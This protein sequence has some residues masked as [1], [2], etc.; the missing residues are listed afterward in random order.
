MDFQQLLNNIVNWVATEGVKI[1]A[2]FVALYLGFKFINIVCRRIEKGFHKK[3]VDITIATAFVSTLRKVLKILAIICFIGFIGIETS[4]IA[5]AIASCGVAIGLALQGSLSN[6]AGGVVILF[7]RPYKIGDYVMIG[8]EE[9]TVEKIELFYTYLTTTDNKIIIIPNANASNETIINYSK[10]DSRRVDMVFQIAYENDFEKAKEIIESCAKSTGY[11]L[12]D[13]PLFVRVSAH[14]ASS[15]DIKAKMW[16]KSD[17]YWALYHDML[18][19]VKKAFDENE[20]S[21]P[22]QQIDVQI[23]K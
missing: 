21:I 15:I 17:D 23:K 11:L 20:I 9:G 7:M 18:E 6:F 14:N 5:A 16:T 3:E 2:G 4:S 8:G 13:H 10:K 12:E 1:I 22:Y 19:K